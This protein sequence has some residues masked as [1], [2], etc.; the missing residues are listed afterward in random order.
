MRHFKLLTLL[1]LAAILV[2]DLAQAGP[3][4]FGSHKTRSP[5][6]LG[7]FGPLYVAL[8]FSDDGQSP[9]EDTCAGQWPGDV[10]SD[11]ALDINDATA[12]QSFLIW[13]MP[14]PQPLSNADVNGDCRINIGDFVCLLSMFSGG[15]CIVTCTCVNPDTTICCFGERG[16]VDSDWQDQVDVSDLIYLVD[17]SFNSGYAPVCFEEADVNGDLEVDIADIIY[18]ID[19]SFGSPQGPAPVSCP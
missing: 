18:L 10:N 4:Q 8:A 16:N 17:Y 15:A 5:H 2:A 19:Y 6:R 13:G 12:L 11:G 1:G 9:A 3:R 14:I 7:N